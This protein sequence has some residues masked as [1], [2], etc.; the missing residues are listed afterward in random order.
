MQ[1]SSAGFK[2]EHRCFIMNEAQV[3]EDELIKI[4]MVCQDFPLASEIRNQISRDLK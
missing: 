1:D 3:L 4:Q 2:I